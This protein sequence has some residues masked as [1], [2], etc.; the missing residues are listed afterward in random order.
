MYVIIILNRSIC[1]QPSTQPPSST[2]ISLAAL[3]LQVGN[4][5]NAK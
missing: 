3:G 4:F 1:P 5:G 2:V